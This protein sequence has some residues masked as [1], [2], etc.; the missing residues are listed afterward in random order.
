MKCK[1]TIEMDNAAFDEESNGQG[2]E[3]A[4]ILRELADT[5][6][7]SILEVDDAWS[8]I[9]RNGNRVGSLNIRK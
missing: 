4:R 3:L 7:E 6:D 8:A 5:V 2:R 9:D 1:I